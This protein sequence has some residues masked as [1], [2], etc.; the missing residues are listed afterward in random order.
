MLFWMVHVKIKVASIAENASF[1]TCTFLARMNH[2][3]KYYS[4]CFYLSLKISQI[5]MKN[6]SNTCINVI[7][8]QKVTN[9]KQEFIDES[10]TT[11]SWN[12]DVCPCCH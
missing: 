9:K 4:I 6:K 12:S 5:P 11:G 2:Q 8:N 3:S 10:Y 7:V 1:I